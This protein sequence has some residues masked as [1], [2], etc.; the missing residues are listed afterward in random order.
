[1]KKE[2][3]GARTVEAFIDYIKKQLEN[4]LQE[5]TSLQQLVEIDVK[6]HILTC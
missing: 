3:R 2:Y 1:M 4:P 6:L 5:F